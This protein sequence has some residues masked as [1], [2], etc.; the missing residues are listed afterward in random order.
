[1]TKIKDFKQN[2]KFRDSYN[3]FTISLNTD[4]GNHRKTL[5]NFESEIFE[6]CNYETSPQFVKDRFDFW[7]MGGKI[8]SSM[9]RQHG[10]IG[11]FS[12]HYLLMKKIV[13]EKI[14]MALI[15][16]DDALQKQP[17]PDP[18]IFPSDQ[19][20]L[21]G[22]FFFHPTN[23]NLTKKWEKYCLSCYSNLSVELTRLT[24]TK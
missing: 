10:T 2:D 11:C 1:M 14:D 17:L 22:A 19:P 24:T 18:K 9:K 3:I 15:T 21:L 23:F 5:L 7:K 8:V 13:E 16:E 6:A 12:S 4:T 20:T